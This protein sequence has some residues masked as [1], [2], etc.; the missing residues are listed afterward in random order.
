MVQVGPT[1][2]PMRHLLGPLLPLLAVACAPAAP[3]AARD[4]ARILAGDIAFYESRLPR[5]P[6][7]A[8]DRAVLGGLYL[9]RSRA[10]GSASDLARAETLARASLGLRR[11]RNADAARV[12]VASLMAGHRFAEARRVLWPLGVAAPEDIVTRAT[13]GE[14]ALELGRYAEADSLFGGLGLQRMEPAVGPRYA[15]WLELSG[16]SGAARELLEALRDRQATAYRVPA[17]E[18]AWLDLRLGDLAMRNGR[19]D[20][21]ARALARGR[22]L[23]PADHRLLAAS[24]RLGAGAEHW[25]EAV[26]FA[27]S[28]LALLP[29]PGTL[30]VLLDAARAQGD[31]GAAAEYRRALQATTGG[32]P[33]ALHRDWA[34]YLLDHQGTDSAL[35]AAIAAQHAE[36]HDVYT[37]DLAAWARYR[38]GDLAGA[39]VLADS[40][41]LRHVRDATLYA[42]AARIALATGDRRAAR[43]WV[44]E[45]VAIAPRF[46]APLARDARALL[47]S[48]EAVP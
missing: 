28:A 32:G 20:L 44:R 24:A 18:L 34:L 6:Y 9:T 2:L 31:T 8:R 42:H 4:D 45:A 43:A 37:H 46:P 35:L 33:A 12:L 39:R 1:G 15:R 30:V 16:E 25:T 47:D 11:G 36:R 29:E 26:R 22:R 3:P 19:P 21:A 17:S 27:D 5:D 10:T 48:L 38:T 40:A 13:L 7:G 14:L 41:L 23:A